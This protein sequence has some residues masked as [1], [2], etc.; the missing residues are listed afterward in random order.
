M[1]FAEIRDGSAY[2]FIV[3][4]PVMR[5]FDADCVFPGFAAEVGG[6]SSVGRGVD[7][8]S[9]EQ[10]VAQIAAQALSIAQIARFAVR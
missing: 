8:S 4:F 2:F 6:S 7:A 1:R 10:I 5:A 3:E 9:V